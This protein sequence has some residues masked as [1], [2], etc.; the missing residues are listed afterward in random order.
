MSIN[1]KLRT[2]ISMATSAVAADA[3][4]AVLENEVVLKWLEGKAPKKII[5]VPNKMINVV[6]G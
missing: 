1:G 6:L 4:K 2:T 5:F 3:E